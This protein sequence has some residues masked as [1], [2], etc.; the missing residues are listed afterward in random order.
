MALHIVEY[1]DIHLLL[2]FRLAPLLYSNRTIVSI[3]KR[4]YDMRFINKRDAYED[5]QND[6]NMAS[7]YI[8]FRVFYDH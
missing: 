7:R 1:R 3:R 8:K 2:L 5:L 4:V 6:L